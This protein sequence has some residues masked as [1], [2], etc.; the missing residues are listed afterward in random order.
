M[1]GWKWIRSELRITNYAW[2]RWRQKQRKLWLGQW[3]TW[4]WRNVVVILPRNQHGGRH[5]YLPTRNSANARKHETNMLLTKAASAESDDDTRNLSL[6]SISPACNTEVPSFTIKSCF[7]QQK[8]CNSAPSAL[9]IKH[10]KDHWC[11]ISKCSSWVTF[12]L[13]FASINNDILKFM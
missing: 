13:R 3:M 4:H 10:N 2:R 5:S 12:E 7:F 8:K 11:F 6:M 1:L 9:I